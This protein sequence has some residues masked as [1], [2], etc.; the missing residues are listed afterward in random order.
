MSNLDIK[1]KA[2]YELTQ[3]ERLVKQLSYNHM[4]L[5]VKNEDGLSKLEE[6]GYGRLFSCNSTLVAIIAEKIGQVKEA[7]DQIAI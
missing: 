7:I 1:D 6:Y 4:D 3:A 2:Y 5:N